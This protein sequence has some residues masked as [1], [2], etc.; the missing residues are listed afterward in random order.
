MNRYRAK[1][2]NPTEVGRLRIFLRWSALVA[3]LV[4]L[5]LWFGWYLQ[6]LA[7]PIA[8]DSDMV[9]EITIILL[10]LLYALLLAIP[11]I[12][13]VEIG[14][15]VLAV[16][17]SAA[18]PFVYLATVLGLCIGFAFGTI[19]SDR[20]SCRFLMTLGLNRACYFIDEIKLLSREERLKRLD[21]ALPS[22]AGHWLVDHRYIVLAVL[23]N[24]PGNSLLGGGGGIV[25][26]AGLSRTFAT[27]RFVLTIAVATLPIPLMVYL[28]GTP[29]GR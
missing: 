1:P 24:L 15:A 16:H 2:S 29:I 28:L 20:M 21:Q 9:L 26:L 17:G 3:V 22:W 4:A 6:N 13:G 7:A 19:L 10:L 11:F 8:E 14:I 5:N 23:L 27:L 18:A 25:M 12:P